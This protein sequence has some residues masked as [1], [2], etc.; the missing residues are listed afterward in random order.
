MLRV[1]SSGPQQVA[2]CLARCKE[3]WR[4]KRN[5]RDHGTPKTHEHVIG[6]TDTTL[7]D[8][9]RVS[10]PAAECSAPRETVLALRWARRTDMVLVDPV[11]PRVMVVLMVTRNSSANPQE[12]HRRAIGN[13][14]DIHWNSLQ[15]TT[16]F[17]KIFIQIRE[18]PEKWLVV[19]K[20][21]FRDQR[22]GEIT[23]SRSTESQKMLETLTWPKLH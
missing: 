18:R 21:D 11:A 22:L 14:L 23:T 20:P 5:A 12:T 8:C 10:C 15:K 9:L 4:G 2:M 1:D 6:Q 19:C 13:P 7:F 3:V 16:H 17:E